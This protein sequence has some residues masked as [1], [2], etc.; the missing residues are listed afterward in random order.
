MPCGIDI[1]RV[2]TCFI[3]TIITQ[4]TEQVLDIS[5]CVRAVWL[6]LLHVH[7]NIKAL[8]LHH[9]YFVFSN[10]HIVKLVTLKKKWG[11]IVNIKWFKQNNMCLNVIDNFI[12]KGGVI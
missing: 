1:D 6:N 9:I 10:V 4:I 11:M 12:I 7:F 3:L 2:I 5:K 8:S